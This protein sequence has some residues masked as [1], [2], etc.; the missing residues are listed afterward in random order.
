MFAV[1]ELATLGTEPFCT[2][3]LLVMEENQALHSTSKGGF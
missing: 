3:I 2:E 1:R